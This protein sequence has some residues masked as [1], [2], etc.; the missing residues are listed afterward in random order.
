MIADCLMY[1]C[2][3]GL[4]I[5]ES[6]NNIEPIISFLFALE[7]KKKDKMKH[8]LCLYDYLKKWYNRQ[9]CISI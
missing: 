9:V 5:N 1:L 4:I 2:T 6:D 8:K 3:C 7:I